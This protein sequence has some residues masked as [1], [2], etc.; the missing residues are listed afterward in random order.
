[1][2]LLSTIPPKILLQM[3]LRGPESAPSLENEPHFTIL[4]PSSESRCIPMLKLVSAA[5]FHHADVHSLDSFNSMALSRW[6]IR[7]G[8]LDLFSRILFRTSSTY[9]PNELA[10]LSL[11]SKP[12]TFDTRWV[13]DLRRVAREIAQSSFS[14]CRFTD[15]PPIGFGD[16]FPV[17]LSS[18]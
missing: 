18:Q 16:S 3:A 6:K 15:F 9:L 8:F 12:P 2:A 1:M 13:C 7:L 4:F 11:D 5:R 17:Y 14:G 10:L